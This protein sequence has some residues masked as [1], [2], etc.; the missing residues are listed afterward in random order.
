MFIF[1][2]LQQPQTTSYAESLSQHSPPYYPH[3]VWYSMGVLS[4]LYQSISKFQRRNR[5]NSCSWN[6]LNDVDGFID[7]TTL[8]D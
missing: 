8:T 6:S 4:G 7:R 2:Y 3:N 5:Y 1:V